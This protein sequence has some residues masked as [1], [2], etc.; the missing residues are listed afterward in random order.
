MTE[1]NGNLELGF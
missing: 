1:E